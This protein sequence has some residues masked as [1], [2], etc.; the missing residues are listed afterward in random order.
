MRGFA[1][2]YISYNIDHGGDSMPVVCVVMLDSLTSELLARTV[3]KATITSRKLCSAN[4]I[5][6]ICDAVHTIPRSF[7]PGAA[8][9]RARRPPFSAGKHI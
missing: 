4:V 8:P 9:Q 1:K 3:S 7:S 5:S 6:D 2:E